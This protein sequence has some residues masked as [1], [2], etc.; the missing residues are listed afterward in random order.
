MKKVKA[1]IQQQGVWFQSN[2]LSSSV[3]YNQITSYKFSGNLNLQV[4]EDTLKSIVENNEILRTN[5]VLEGNELNQLIHADFDISTYIEVVDLKVLEPYSERVNKAKE[6]ELETSKYSFD[7]ENDRLLKVKI[8]LLKENEFVIIFQRNHIIFDVQSF[9]IF[10]ERFVFIYNNSIQKITKNLTPLNQYKSYAKEQEIYRKSYE[11]YTSFNFWKENLKGYQDQITQS[12][13]YNVSEGDFEIESVHMDLPEKITHKISTYALKKRVLKS[14]IYNLAFNVLLNKYFGID[15]IVI[16]NVFGNRRINGKDFSKSL[17]LYAN[18]LLFR[19]RLDEKQLL[20]DELVKINS[21]LLDVY[22]HGSINNEDIQRELHLTGPVVRFSLNMFKEPNTDL[23][24]E[25]LNSEYWEEIESSLNHFSQFD[26]SFNFHEKK[27]KTQIRALYKKSIF[28]KAQAIQLQKSFIQLIDIILN[29]SE[30][31]ISGISLLLE[32]EQN[33]IL[34]QFNQTEKKLDPI[35]P[36]SVQIEHVALKYPNKIA[37]STATQQISYLTLNNFSNKI[38]HVLRKNEV[39]LNSLVGIFM[40]RIPEMI[41]SVLG[42]LK[43]GGAYTPIEINQPEAR[44]EKLLQ[45]SG[46]NHLIVSIRQLNTYYELIKRNRHITHI[47]CINDDDSQVELSQKQHI[48]YR[49]IFNEQSVDNLN[50]DIS[51]DSIAYVMYTSGSTGVPKGVVINQETV[52][53]V[54]QG[55][56]NRFNVSANEKLLFVTSLGFDLSVYDIFGTLCSGSEIRIASDDENIEPEMLCDIIINEGITI[57]NSAPPV[58]QRLIPFIKS[59]KYELSDSNLRLVMLSG[60]WI[61]LQMPK[62]L[63]MESP[64]IEVVSLGGATEN[65]IWSHYYVIDSID[66]SWKSIPYGKPLQNVKCYVLDKNLKVCPIGVQGDLYIGGNCLALGYFNDPVITSQRFIPN[67]FIPN[68]I[69]YNT[70]DQARWF[71]DGNLEFLGRNDNQVKIRGHRIELGEI[72]NQLISHPKIK[73][74]VI[75]DFG[76]RLD[77]YI[78]G[79]YIAEEQVGQEELI[80]YLASRLPSYMIPSYLIPITSIPLTVNGKIDYKSL[81]EPNE[82]DVKTG[83]PISP[84]EQ[85]ISTL[86]NDVLGKKDLSVNSDFFAFGGHSL[87]AADLLVKINDTFQVGLKIRD[88]FS[89]PT[90][91]GL[92]SLVDQ[93][94]KSK[95]SKIPKA[96]QKPFYHVTPSQKRLYMLCQFDNIGLTYNIPQT[97]LIQGDLNLDRLE[98]SVRKLVERHEPLRTSFR[99]VDN[100]PVQKIY[101]RIEF[102]IEYEKIDDSELEEHINASIKKFDLSKPGLFRIKVFK[103]NEHKTVLFFDFHHI[104]MDGVSLVIFYKELNALYTGHNLDDFEIQSKDFSEWKHD[105][106]GQNRGINQRQYWQERFSDTIETLNLPLDHPRPAIYNFEGTSFSFELEGELYDRIKEYTA[107][108]SVTLFTFLLGAFGI[109]LSKY[110]RSSDIIIGTVNANRNHKDIMNSL[111]L[112]MNILPLRIFPEHDKKISDFFTELKKDILQAF[113][114][115]DYNLEDI[116]NHLNI[117]HD[118]SRNA[119][120]DVLFVLQNTE[121]LDE[122]F[123]DKQAT[124]LNFEGQYSRYDITLVSEEQ[125]DENR[126]KFYFEYNTNLFSLT[127]IQQMSDLY[128]KVLDQCAKISNS[129]IGNIELLDNKEKKSLINSLNSPKVEYPHQ[130]LIHTVF[131]ETVIKNPD[132]IA[133]YSNTGNI[134]YEELNKK[135]NQLARYLLTFQLPNESIIALKMDRSIDMIVTILGI[136]KAGYAYLPIGVDYPLKRIRAVIEKSQTKLLITY[137]KQLTDT[138][139]ACITFNDIKFNTYSGENLD[140]PIS[141]NNLAYTIFTSG[142]T[143]TPKGVMVEHTSVINRIHW[144]QRKYPIDHNDVIL[145]KTTYTFDVS[146]WELFWWMLSG[147]SLALLNMG[148][149]K[150]PAVIAKTIDKYSISVLHFVP[151]MLQVFLKYLEDYISIHELKSLKYIFAS[152]EELKINHVHSIQNLFKGNSNT[153]L[154]NL[155]GPTEATVDVSYFD[156]PQQKQL[157]KVPIGKPIDNIELYIMDDDCEILPVGVPGELG[158]SGIG[159]ARG[160]INDEYLTQ[161]KFVENPYKE[162]ERIYK[163]GDLA[164]WLPDGNIEF[165]GRLN[166]DSQV[167]IRG[168]RIELGEV[169]SHLLDLDFISNTVVASV[170]TDGLSKQLVAYLVLDQKILAELKSDDKIIQ[171][172]QKLGIQ[173]KKYP[174]GMRLFYVNKTETD[175][176]YQ[177]IVENNEYLKHNITLPPQ[178]CVIDI[179]ANIGM[180]T[181][182]INH[183][184]PSAEIYSFEPIK[185]V[186]EVLEYNARLTNNNKIKPF[187]VGIGDEEKV[188]SFTYYPKNTILSSSFGNIEE[189][190]HVV[191]TFITNSDTHGLSEEQ[192]KNLVQNE[193]VSEQLD[194]N[195]KTLSHIIKDNNIDHIHLVKIDVE[196]GEF[197]V[198]NGIDEDHWSKIDQLII[199]IHDVENRLNKITKLLKD[200]NFSIVVEQVK[201]LEGTNLY[202]MYATKVGLD[203]VKD[204]VEYKP[205]SK[206]Q[207]IADVK[208]SALKHLNLSLP[209][210]MHP[211]H[212]V[213][214]DELPIL[215]NGKIDR[216]NLPDPV[217][218]KT[219]FF[220]P[221]NETDTKLVHI[222]KD[223]LGVKERDLSIK[224]DYFK[225]GGNSLSATLMLLVVAQEFEVSVSLIE[226]YKSPSLESLS[227]FIAS[228]I[229]NKNL[230]D[231]EFKT[232]EL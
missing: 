61:P 71:N 180:F 4:F 223:S 108:N 129:S 27:D 127:T 212:F 96:Q 227:D 103:L 178:A 14:A 54:L 137:D 48:I 104:I 90:I 160:Y 148:E 199:E 102:E 77:K 74:V 192:I 36:I 97:I 140:L 184:Y 9:V 157:K 208:E 38:A 94:S 44:I 111:G 65:T 116:I 154:I 3:F 119:L 69:I 158:I 87:K 150:N 25:G 55:V 50:V 170:G 53:N 164:R 46:V 86:F 156:C 195:I 152:G 162:G 39:G 40:E 193:L 52:I 159:L 37:L 171:E 18:I 16:G 173:L 51:L 12:I 196:K 209:E 56:N 107:K 95:I 126:L 143:G 109:L 99:I 101:D 147:S 45:L 19:N 219:E 203:Y 110:S 29:D 205:T 92:S 24:L 66:E 114:N 131:E 229:N 153:N 221:R 149:E 145:Q 146:V 84:L 190:T 62:I 185:P 59:N 130:S 32:K 142:S 1:T 136:L 225:I 211:Q 224:L 133:I 189:E 26:L 182:Y 214:L 194:C 183:L 139:I 49:G 98:T 28:T 217:M 197:E 80:Q 47:Y 117:Q 85:Q 124:K 78:N 115:Q 17:G 206:I 175:F 151:S 123:L 144:M 75:K 220:P 93:A 163:T 174:N 155:Y 161:E 204:K 105:Q 91:R 232:I 68:E 63:K 2:K 186:F 226:F 201:E 218:E 134:S 23:G 41:Y 5:F 176:M 7:L 57:W 207:D 166:N 82:N 30:Q 88:I 31:H 179:G 35:A 228:K 213:I 100:T 106:V 177:E 67:P 120:F 21:N 10:L 125:E 138:Q 188:V 135:S 200:K 79:Y 165:L 22:S 210:Y 81:P 15:D 198:I 72:K 132:Q 216:K 20:S 181:R 76:E 42:V 112:F 172:A 113:E 73:D 187:N 141:P 6:I 58:L 169:E 122:D 128:I 118:M 60:D 202:N 34:E 167:K 43:S 83:K 231:S 230:E 70:G 13:S 222:W 191:Q 168:F 121:S 64:G 8:L 215:S 11:F 33:R 89:T